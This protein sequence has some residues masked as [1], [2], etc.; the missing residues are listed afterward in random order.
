MLISIDILAFF[1]CFLTYITTYIVIAKIRRLSKKI[2]EKMERLVII[3]L[4]ISILSSTYISTGSM[5]DALG[6]LFDFSIKLSSNSLISQDEENLY[7]RSKFF[8][9]RNFFGEDLSLRYL[10]EMLLR[11][12]KIVNK[13]SELM[14]KNISV[15]INLRMKEL[16]GLEERFSLLIFAYFFY[17]FFV[18]QIFLF[19]FSIFLIPSIGLIHLMVCIYLFNQ[20]KKSFQEVINFE[21]RMIGAEYIE[22]K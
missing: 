22:K 20:L 3:P 10:L 8:S 2:R 14:S 13:L 6:M 18:F 15:I 21:K 12:P 1:L 9:E 11:S 4:I 19:S 7:V 5:R 16:E 17:P